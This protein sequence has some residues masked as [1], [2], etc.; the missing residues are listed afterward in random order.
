M[1]IRK[2]VEFSW[3]GKKKKLI[4]DMLIIER[5]NNE[6]GITN[7]TKFD[8]D[9]FDFVKI[10][11][12]YY[13]IFDE[14]GFDAKWM[15]IYDIIFIADDVSK[16]GIAKDYFEHVKQFLPNFNAPA[17]KKKSIPKKRSKS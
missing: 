7:L 1:A 4:I 16:A 11:K 8:P 13:I 2:P 10:S 9:N 17:L 6:I 5:V 12:F 14:C 3:K 15:D